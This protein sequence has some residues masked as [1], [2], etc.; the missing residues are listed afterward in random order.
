M[1][2]RWIHALACGALALGGLGAG[3]LAQAGS[4]VY[5]QLGVSTP[6]VVGLQVG[7]VPPLVAAPVVYAT[8]T[9]VYVQHPVMV[10][11]PLYQP[12]YYPAPVRI[13]SAKPR[14]PQTMYR[15][16]GHH[17]KPSY[18]PQHRPSHKPA[19]KPAHKPSH[20]PGHRR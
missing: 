14:P 7:N 15:P 3:T 8:P 20:K 16:G 9:P 4:D 12:V 2:K 10:S 18:K 1:S 13:H 17:G 6:G 5:W 19:H 11:Q